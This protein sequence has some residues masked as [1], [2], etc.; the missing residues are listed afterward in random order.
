VFCHFGL[1][2]ENI[3]VKISFEVRVV[4]KLPRLTWWTAE[5]SILEALLVELGLRSR[6]RYQDVAS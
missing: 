2:G 5:A 1:R 3:E 4:F 6:L